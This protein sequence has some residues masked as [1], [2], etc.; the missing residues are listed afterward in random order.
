MPFQP[1]ILITDALLFLLTLAVVS[2]IFMVR[3]RPHLRRPWEKVLKRKTGAV[4]L[5]VLLCFY[6][7]ALLDSLHFHPKLENATS[8]QHQ[9][10]NEILSVLDIVMTP[11]RTHVEKTFSAPLSTHLF[12]KVLIVKDGGSK[13]Q[14]YPRLKYGGAHLENPDE[15]KIADITRI[16]AKAIFLAMIVWLIT[17]SL[18]VLWYSKSC[19]CVYFA[20]FK[21]N[22]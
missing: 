12:S 2:F 15:D 11:M 6:S 21:K 5:V 1:V 10:S 18:I 19:N 8:T 16:I 14:V 9:Y 17:W 4:S 22:F 7:A 13:E 20:S 3:S